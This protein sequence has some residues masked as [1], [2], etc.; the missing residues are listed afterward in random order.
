M[1][2][3][4]IDTIREHTAGAGTTIENGMRGL[5]IQPD[6]L[7]FDLTVPAGHTL[8]VQETLDIAAGKTL[9]IEGTVVVL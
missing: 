2:S 3:M 7:A 6:E 4:G 1:S 5:S 9:T 8:Y